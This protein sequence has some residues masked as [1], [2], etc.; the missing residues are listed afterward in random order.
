MKNLKFP[1]KILLFLTLLSLELCLNQSQSL[2]WEGIDQERNSIIEIP[3]GNLVREGLVIEFYDNDDLHMGR[4][5]SMT[6]IASGTEL[7]VEDLNE[8]KQERTLIMRE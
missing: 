4:I 1:P 2:A 8:D 5:T 7:I 6:T 3:S